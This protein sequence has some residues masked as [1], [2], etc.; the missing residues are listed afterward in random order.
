MALLPHSFPKLISFLAFS[1]SS[2]LNGGVCAPSKT[3]CVCP[4]GFYGGRCEHSILSCNSWCTKQGRC[5]E[6][7]CL[8]YIADDAGSASFD[9]R[10]WAGTFLHITSLVLLPFISFVVIEAVS[11]IFTSRLKLLPLLRSRHPLD[12]NSC[13]GFILCSLTIFPGGLI[14]NWNCSLRHYA[15]GSNCHFAC[16]RPDPDCQGANRARCEPETPDVVP[17]A[18]LPSLCKVQPAVPSPPSPPS[19]PSAPPPTDPTSP[20]NPHQTNSGNSVGADVLS[21]SEGFVLGAIIALVAAIMACGV[22]FT[23]FRKD[24]PLANLL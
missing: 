10:C 5:F 4:A 13:D 7:K 20:G 12:F 6:E 11:S 17:I 8:C 21:S 3:L 24:L 19:K 23:F 1:C 18:Q 14:P 22:Y 2:C 15:D 9:K 16:G